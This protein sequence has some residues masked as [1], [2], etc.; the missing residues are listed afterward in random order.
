MM[1]VSINIRQQEEKLKTKKL[2]EIQM[3]NHWEALEEKAGM[4]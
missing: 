2:V 3:F 4:S 1:E